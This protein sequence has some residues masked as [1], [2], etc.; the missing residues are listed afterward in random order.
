[1]NPLLNSESTATNEIMTSRLNRRQDLRKSKKRR[2]LFKLLAIFFMLIALVLGWFYGTASG[3]DLRIVLAEDCLSSQHPWLANFF[4][5][6]AERQKLLQEIFHPK[7]KNSASDTTVPALAQPQI[8]KESD[9]IQSAVIHEKRYTAYVLKIADPS[10]VHLVQ[11][12]Y[13]NKGEALSELLKDTGGL[14]GINAGGFYDPNGNGSG[15]TPIGNVFSNGKLT[16]ADSMT[17]Q[18]LMC[19]FLQ[20]NRFF[21]GNY[22]A[23]EL[24]Q[25]KARDAVHF[26]PEL[27]VDGHPM[28]TYGDGGW[29][30]APRTAI[31]TTE[32]GQVLFVVTN[33]RF[34]DGPWNLGASLKDVQDLLLSYGCVNAMNLDGGGSATMMLDGKLM[35]HPQTDTA[36]GM[37]Y[38]PNA[39]IV[40]PKPGMIMDG[41][42]KLETG[43]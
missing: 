35:N 28:I 3:R 8:E 24:V 12:K 25:M 33:G 36:A 30:Y 41:P 32:D 16:H 5:G 1:M 7:V 17:E 11:T 37:R 27:I 19:G 20:N 10:L 6:A 34:I 39:F 31:G 22:S 29:G 40:M 4:V 23:N 13:S 21:V 26:Y 14:A 2:R 9:L 42:G 18:E 43:E 38:L 15:G